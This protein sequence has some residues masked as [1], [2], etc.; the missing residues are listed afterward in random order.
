M[1]YD[2]NKLS[3]KDVYLSAT[4]TGFVA[5][6]GFNNPTNLYIIHVIIL[7]LFSWARTNI[8]LQQVSPT[9]GNRLAWI[10]KLD[11]FFLFASLCL[12]LNQNMLWSVITLIGASIIHIVH[13]VLLRRTVLDLALSIGFIAWLVL[14]ARNG[15]KFDLALLVGI[16]YLDALYMFVNFKERKS[17]A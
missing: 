17:V 15:Y 9:V 12:A 7:I 13:K 4:I 1:K 10:A 5:F 11:G 3:H 14:F 2:Q 8:D 16:L 6:M